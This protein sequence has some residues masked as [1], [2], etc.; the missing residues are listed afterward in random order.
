MT[1]LNLNMAPGIDVA[2][3]KDTMHSSC[4]GLG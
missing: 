2:V 1:Q 3:G 4:G